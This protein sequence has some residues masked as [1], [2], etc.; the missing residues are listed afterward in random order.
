[1]DISLYD[2]TGK[3][4]IENSED[5]KV[6]ITMPIPD[7]LVP[8]AGNNRVAYV[9][10]GKLVELSPKFTTIN[11]VTCISFVAPHFSP[12]TI[13]VDTK[14]LTAADIQDMTPKTGDGISPKWF[15]AGGLLC[16]S[17]FFFFKR[18]KKKRPVKAN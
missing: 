17:L 5:L 14:N 12:Y 10:N 18:D 9:V 2:S 4:K 13:Y 7:D 8:Y 6:T 16:I 1:M 3:T 15:L 11:G